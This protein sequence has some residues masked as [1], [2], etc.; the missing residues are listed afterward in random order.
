[1]KY[2]IRRQARPPSTPTRARAGGTQQARAAA[3]SR[4]DALAGGAGKE[5]AVRL[6]SFPCRR[7]LKRHDLVNKL[8]GISHPRL[9]LLETKEVSAHLKPPSGQTR[10]SWD[11]PGAAAAVAGTG[12]AGIAGTATRGGRPPLEP[13][14]IGTLAPP[15]GTAGPADR[16]LVDGSARAFARGARITGAFPGE[17]AAGTSYR[18]AQAPTALEPTACSPRFTRID[19]DK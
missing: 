15:P 10:H 1:M 19:E 7:N 11:R 16:V 17:T 5:V 4:E 12:T 8:R 9:I 3:S 2:S 6:N 18:S 14:R 13:L